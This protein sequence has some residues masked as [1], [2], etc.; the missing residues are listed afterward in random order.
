MR[1]ISP[2]ALNS[3]QDEYKGNYQTEQSKKAKNKMN[4]EVAITSFSLENTNTGPRSIETVYTHFSQDETDRSTGLAW[5]FAH[6][7]QPGRPGSR[8]QERIWK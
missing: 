1:P 6:R 4:S 8:S 5:G 7:L 2:F 3:A